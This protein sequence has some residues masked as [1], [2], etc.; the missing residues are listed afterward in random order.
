MT[1]FCS[2]FIS[3]LT[4]F[5]LVL[6]SAQA[7]IDKGL[8]WLA[9]Q[10]QV[11]G[12]YI[13]AE[14]LAT[15][16]QSTS[17]ALRTFSALN[18]N[19]NPTAAHRF[20]ADLPSHNT[21]Y[22][23]RQIIAASNNGTS[24]I[25][26]I[27]QILN[28]QNADGGFGDWANF[29]STPI[30]TALAL[31]SLSIAGYNDTTV[32]SSAIDFLLLAQRTN[33]GFALSKSNNSDVYTTALVTIALQKYFFTY[34]VATSVDAAVNYL[35]Q[36]Q[37]T[38]GGWG[39]PWETALALLAIA[40]LTSDAN[41]YATAV[42]RLIAQQLTNGAWNNDAYSTALVLRALFTVQNVQLPR[43]PSIGFFTGRVIDSISRRPLNGVSVFLDT[44]NGTE[45]LTA[46][47]GKF[48]FTDV[49]P[50]TYSLSYQIN[51]Y[52]TATQTASVSAGQI[53]DLGTI[54][55]TALPTTGFIVGTLT[56]T[57][58]QIPIPQAT[59]QVDVK[60][61]GSWTATTNDDGNYR[62]A[63]S[64]GE[65]TVNALAPGYESITGIATLTAG[66]TLRFSPA[67]FPAGTVTT[68]PTVILS[69]R[70]VDSDT[71][72]PLS[73]VTVTIIETSAL[74]NSDGDGY[75]SLLGLEPGEM[76]VNVTADGYQ[77][78]QF[79][80]L[81]LAG[82]QFDIGVI[83][84]TRV[85]QLTTTTVVGWI[86]DAHTNVGL[87]GVAVT[88]DNTAFSTVSD[89]DGKFRLEGITDLDFILTAGTT[90]YLSTSSPIKL[91][92][93]STLSITLPLEPASVDGLTI[94]E[95]E[96]EQPSYSAYSDALFNTR[97]N[98]T[99]DVSVTTQ[100]VLRVY[101]S[102]GHLLNQAPFVHA[103][104]PNDLSD[105]I[106]TIP[107][108]QL[109]N[110]QFIW[111]TG[112]NAPGIYTIVLQ[113]F[114]L[115]SLQLLA[116]RSTQVEIEST[117]RIKRLAVFP[118]PR[119]SYFNTEETIAINATIEHQSN[120]SVPL[121]IRYTWYQPDGSVLKEGTAQV[122]LVPEQTQTIISLEEFTH[123]FTM[124]G[125]YTAQ[126]DIISGPLPDDVPIYPISVAPGTHIEPKQRVEPNHILP[127]ED[128]RIR[129]HIQLRGHKEG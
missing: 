80:L 58:T 111:E 41:R 7:D 17:E 38:N 14:D 105:S 47:D 32:I 129:L 104:L 87:A 8:A 21:E 93:H 113:A 39:T 114:D 119:F 123:R 42:N 18:A 103:P 5:F 43:D 51:G 59:I 101:D 50:G 71:Q 57:Q 65:V 34:N 67:L 92:Q 121:T 118:M 125:V 35:L 66:A 20:L 13:T 72:L 64:P 16:V 23:A 76:T 74:T 22:L 46:I 33:G 127:G 29:H 77:G 4:L 11:D 84:L 45:V 56:D 88:V 6:T 1:R 31:E 78:V 75:F 115:N 116:E 124:S 102:E 10:S 122:N 27:V 19:H 25:D 60:N 73:G 128:R 26:L 110:T 91:T 89:T 49:D 108:G 53:V 12:S 70:V 107:A 90:G 9:A 44:G 61:V 24:T 96:P 120:I 79:D 62:L 97:F 100:M 69:G 2:A 82:S 54:A 3:I 85:D 106:L 117:E 112:R 126:V 28:H 30:D 98:N 83:A 55:L 37:D 63:V 99:S 36:R 40:P 81:T 95:F 15:A 48:K 94:T 52:I 68:E 109:I 86:V